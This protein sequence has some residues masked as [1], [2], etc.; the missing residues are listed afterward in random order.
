[1]KDRERFYR[2]LEDTYILDKNNPQESSANQLIFTPNGLMTAVT[3][4]QAERYLKEQ[5]EKNKGK[6]DRAR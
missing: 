4:V 1:M 5:I 2:Q 6:P 3:S